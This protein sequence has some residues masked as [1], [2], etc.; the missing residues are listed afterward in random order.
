MI[1]GAFKL[2]FSS[3]HKEKK[4]FCLTICSRVIDV[5]STDSIYGWN[6]YVRNRI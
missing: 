2:Y 4:F 3:L 6:V 1:I 5:Q